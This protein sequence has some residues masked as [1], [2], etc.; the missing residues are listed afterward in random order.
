MNFKTLICLRDF[1]DLGRKTSRQEIRD[2]EDTIARSPRRP[3]PGIKLLP[4]PSR[5]CPHRAPIAAQMSTQKDIRM[6]RRL[7]VR[8]ALAIRDVTDQL[9]RFEFVFQILT[10]RTENDKQ[11]GK[12]VAV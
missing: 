5:F 12:R 3:L 7:L 9:T 4:E 11:L 6:A 10:R 8:H 2:G 1:C